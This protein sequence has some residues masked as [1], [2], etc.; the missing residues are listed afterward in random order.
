M[1]RGFELPMRALFERPEFLGLDTGILNNFGTPS[2][3]NEFAW[4]MGESTFREDE[5]IVEVQKNRFV[6]LHVIPS[7]RPTDRKTVIQRRNSITNAYKSFVDCRL[8][9]LTLGLAEVWYDTNTGYYL[10]STPLR[11]LINAEPNRFE[12]HV[13][14]HQEAKEYLE[15]TIQLIRKHGRSDVQIILTVSPVP[16][17]ATH[18]DVDVM[19]ANT[20]SK[21]LLRVVAEEA[22]TKHEFVTYFPS[23]ESVTLSDRKAAWADDLTHV[24]DEI[25]SVNIT[26]MVDSYV[27]T[28]W[29]LDDHRKAIEKGGHLAAIERSTFLRNAPTDDAR[30]FFDAFGSF[31][32]DSI[33]FACEHAS[34]LFGLGD[35]ESCLSVIDRAPLD[36]TGRLAQIKTRCYLKLDRDGEAFTTIDKVARSGTKANSVWMLLLDSAKSQND[37][38]LVID[39]L[40]RWI[41]RVPQKAARANALVGRWFHDQGDYQKALKFFEIG[42]NL[43]SEDALIGIYHVESLIALAEFD[44]ARTVF[45]DVNPRLPNEHILHSRLKSRLSA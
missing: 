44:A 26:R 2:I 25:V 33:E 18:R 17:T 13:L 16:L 30:D 1:K 41:K 7:M 36:E 3:Y 24:T 35:Y 29:T 20:Y 12:L 6:D 42:K 28:K 40:N 22:V 8:V 5:H 43:D 10:N 45:D 21:S 14:S 4:A 27:G 39:V 32:K 19:V 15:R 9:I 23:Y 31:S 11:S 37:A 34:W 38:T